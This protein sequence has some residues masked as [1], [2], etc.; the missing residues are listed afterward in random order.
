MGWAARLNRVGVR[1]GQPVST[2]KVRRPDVMS[3]FREGKT[4]QQTKDEIIEQL[5]LMDRMGIRQ[6][7]TLS[8]SVDTIKSDR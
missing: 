6:P 7:G 4:L 2:S 1:T 8:I 5:E 3:L